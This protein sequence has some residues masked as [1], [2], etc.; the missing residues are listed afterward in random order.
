MSAHAQTSGVQRGVFE[1]RDVEEITEFL[2]ATYIGNRTTFG[3][4]HGE[5]R[6][7]AVTTATPAIAADHIRSTIDYTGTADPFDYYFFYIC[8]HGR[9]RVDHV[10][11]EQRLV[12]GDATFYATGQPFDYD[13]QSVGLQVL[14]LPPG[15]LE[16][17][18]EDLT[19]VPASEVRF[20]SGTPISGAA[21][22]RWTDT[23]V[24][25][26]KALSGSDAPPPSPVLAE[27]MARLLVATA[28]ETFPNTTMDRHLQP[29][30]SHVA[31]AAAR[32]AM[33]YIERHADQQVALADIAAAAGTSARALQYGFRRHLDTT[34]LG[35]LQQV[36]LSRAHEDLRAAD[37][38][39]GDTVA[40]IAARWGFADPSRFAAA[41]RAKFAVKPSE[42]L[43]N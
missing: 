19:D 2:R 18:A 23:F 27:G 28:L 20:A 41:Y 40:V 12:P 42:T 38:T 14:R 3:A 1:T 33:T 37:P 24:F 35:Y 4:V 6:W 9:M 31:P 39:R 30:P 15:R 22:R 36:R 10:D 26:S 25:V 21:H 32:R 43:R 34:P 29:G 7:R 11:G 5:A 13:L 16:Q 17:I 8:R